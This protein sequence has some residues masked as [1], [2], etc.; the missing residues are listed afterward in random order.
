MIFNTQGTFKIKSF[1]F[2]AKILQTFFYGSIRTCLF[3]WQAQEMFSLGD[4]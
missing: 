1:N 4:I 3:F 2:I